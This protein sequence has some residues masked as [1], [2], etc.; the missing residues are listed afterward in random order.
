VKL[1][2]KLLTEAAGSF[3]FM[4]VIALAPG[5]GAL[6]PLAIGLALAAMVYMGGHVSGAQ[7][8]P[9]VTFSLFLR[10]VVDGSTLGA[11]WAVQVVAAILAFSFAYLLTGHAPGVHPGAGVLWYSA[12][13]AEIVFTGALALVVLNVAATRATS[14]NSFYGIAIGFTVAAGAFAVGPISGAAFNPA[15]GIGGTVAGAMFA[16][17]SWTDLWLYVA[18]PLVGAAIAAGIHALQEPAAPVTPES[19]ERNLER[20]PEPAG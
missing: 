8:N 13:A 14:G 18:G 19:S 4:T 9:A 5:M 20:E 6:A 1:Q 10:R 7:Y 15:V 12:L 17:G 11:Y 16:N 3:V 2:A